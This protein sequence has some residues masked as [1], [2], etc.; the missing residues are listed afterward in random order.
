MV[1]ACPKSATHSLHHGGTTHWIHM[2]E[3]K[4]SSSGLLGVLAA[5]SLGFGLALAAS[6]QTFGHS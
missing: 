5:N 6:C 4:W 2:E 1:M 3:M